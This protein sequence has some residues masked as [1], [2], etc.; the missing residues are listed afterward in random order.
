MGFTNRGFKLH[1]YC[2]HA[3]QLA[4][5]IAPSRCEKGKVP[6]GRY[7]PRVNSV[8][9]YCSGAHRVG[10]HPLDGVDKHAIP[11]GIHYRALDDH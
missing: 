7:L 3:T 8:Q 6:P 1:L 4:L 2:S 5:V 11:F 9:G 10:P